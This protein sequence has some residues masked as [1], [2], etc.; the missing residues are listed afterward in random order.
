MRA[1]T[2][3]LIQRVSPLVRSLPAGT[4]ATPVLENTGAWLP[5]TPHGGLCPRFLVCDHSFIFSY[6][7]A[8][9]LPPMFSRSARTP[10]WVL[11]TTLMPAVHSIQ[12]RL[13]YNAPLILHHISAGARVCWHFDYDAARS[14][15][16]HPAQ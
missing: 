8:G 4:C 5:R 6:S 2:V 3:S 12:R 10:E 9:I 11:Y 16:W 15:S 14:H 1:H 7:S 13:P